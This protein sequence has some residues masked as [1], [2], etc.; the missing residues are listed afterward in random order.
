MHIT[1]EA[2]YALRIVDTLARSTNRMEAKAIAEKSC[3][4]L[5]FSLK[6]LR[7][8]VASGIVKSY[9]GS[10]G[11]YEVAKPLEEIT[12]YEVLETI[13]GPVA[14]NRCVLEDHVCSRVP[15]K[16]CPY[17]YMFEHVSDHIRAQLSAVT[18]AS[19]VG[20]EHAALPEAVLSRA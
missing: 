15:D 20:Q 11:G 3:V 17:H 16:K 14:L 8:L 12:V 4:T 13:E 1:R 7:K 6:I 19:V 10:Q 18:I 5:R 2:D 9:K